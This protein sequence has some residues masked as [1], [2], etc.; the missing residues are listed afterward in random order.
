MTQKELILKLIEASGT[1]GVST[2]ELRNET[3][4]VDVPKCVSDLR[5]DGYS[6]GS[7]ENGDGTVT[8]FMEYQQTQQWIQMPNGSYAWVNKG[9][10]KVQ[11]KPRKKKQHIDPNWRNWAAIDPMTGERV[12]I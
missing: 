5:K 7:V 10:Q 9:V 8:Y 11:A 2:N 6:I 4:A 3:H 1:R 12:Q